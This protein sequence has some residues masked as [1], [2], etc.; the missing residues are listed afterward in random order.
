MSSRTLSNCF[1]VSLNLRT[2]LKCTY[3]QERRSEV[4]DQRSEKGCTLGF[5]TYPPCPSFAPFPTSLSWAH[6]PLP[7]W[8]LVSHPPSSQPLTT[9]FPPLY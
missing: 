9:L 5:L 1:F 4:R 3:R 7:L 8:P 6:P 2:S